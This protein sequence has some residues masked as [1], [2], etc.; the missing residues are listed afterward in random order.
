M[1][2][3]SSRKYRTA[4]MIIQSILEECM[5]GENKAGMVKSQIYKNLGLK[6]AVGEKYLEQLIAAQY[7]TLTVEQWGKE[8]TRHM[9]KITPRGMQ[10]FEWF[11]K[12]SNELSI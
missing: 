7:I 10:R 5:K 4:L 8:R 11:I 2:G 1:P 9:I 3:S 6:T 12:L